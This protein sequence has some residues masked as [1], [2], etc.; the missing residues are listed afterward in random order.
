MKNPFDALLSLGPLERRKVGLLTGWFFLVITTLWLLKP[1]RS[2]SLLTHL[3]SGEIPYVRLGSVAVVGVVV[4]LYSR[5]VDRFSRVNVARGA[6]LL[7]AAVL[8]MFWLALTTGG[9]ALG[10]Q[11][12]FVWSV[13][14]MVDVY[15]TVM[16]GL[17]WTYTNDVV[18]REN[19]STILE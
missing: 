18:T 19:R 2:A 5:I 13:F 9:D 17:F 12:W 6:S 11:R 16:I 3:G 7:F 15:S 8:V 14:I 4:A 10:S 1:I